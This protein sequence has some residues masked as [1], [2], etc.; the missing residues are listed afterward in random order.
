[1][2]AP[3]SKSLEV[4][5][6]QMEDGSRIHY[7]SLGAGRTY[8]LGKGVLYSV[9]VGPQAEGYAPLIIA[10]GE[11]QLR[12]HGRCIYMVDSRLSNQMSTGF[13]DQMTA[14]F[15]AN[16]GKVS[17]NMLIKSRLL[18]MGLNVA[19]LIIGMRAAKAYSNVN[20]WEAVG[21]REIAGFKLRPLELPD[22]LRHLLPRT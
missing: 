2:S 1:M 18:E 3:Q 6:R 19:N 10:D 8:D 4:F 15:K 9:A 16:R 13:R 7:S 11:E 14:F 22:D 12:K 21:R 5:Q 17:V 20:E